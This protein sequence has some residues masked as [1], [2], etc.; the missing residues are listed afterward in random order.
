MS[1]TTVTE[2]VT[3]NA[4][5]GSP[6]APVKPVEDGPAAFS[7]SSEA[8]QGYKYLSTSDVDHFLTKGWLLVPNAIKQD[9]IDSW[10]KDLFVRIGYDEHDKSTWHT[11]YLHLPRHRE[12]SAEEFC[13]DAWNKITEIAGG[14]DRID[15]VRRRVHRQLWVRGQDETPRGQVSPAGEIGLARRRRLVP[16]LPRLE[17]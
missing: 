6:A 4:L 12:V 3:A 7:S 11:E 2:T 10:M 9:Y 1:S 16:L 5:A 15:P 17:R 14:L 13:P 8:N